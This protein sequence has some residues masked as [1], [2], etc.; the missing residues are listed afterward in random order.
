MNKKAT[1]W[2]SRVVVHLQLKGAHTSRALTGAYRSVTYRKSL[3]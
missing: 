1:Y 2:F 3:E